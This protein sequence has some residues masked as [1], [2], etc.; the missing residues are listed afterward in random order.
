MKAIQYRSPGGLSNLSIGQ[1]EDPGA[2]G[3]G[4]IRVKIDACSLN[5]HDYNVALGVLPVEDGRIMMSDGAGIIEAIGT[6][7]A[8][9]AI[10]DRVVSTFFPDWR[11][12]NAPLATFARASGDGLDGYGVETVVRSANWFTHAVGHQLG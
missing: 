4:E 11:Q 6:E 8:S 3:A 2:P 9:F 1:T 12:G 10:G 7:V 5:R